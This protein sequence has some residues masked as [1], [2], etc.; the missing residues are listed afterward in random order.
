MPVRSP[1]TDIHLTVR[2]DMILV[3][4]SCC[5]R[6]CVHGARRSSTFGKGCMCTWNIVEC[7]CSDPI[8]LAAD[9]AD[10]LFDIHCSFNIS[11]I[12]PRDMLEALLRVLECTPR[13]VGVECYFTGGGTH[14]RRLCGRGETP[15]QHLMR[16]VGE[17]FWSRSRNNFLRACARGYFFLRTPISPEH[18]LPA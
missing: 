11:H 8:R 3:V 2:P 6:V 9:V 13:T 18:L 17:F 14:F 1:T 16:V 12:R 15:R 5:F 7:S 10:P 4:F